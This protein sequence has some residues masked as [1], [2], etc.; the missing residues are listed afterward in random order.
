MKEDSINKEHLATSNKIEKALQHMNTI[1]SIKLH[2]NKKL[3]LLRSYHPRDFKVCP[4]IHRKL[5]V[6]RSQLTY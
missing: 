5:V 3:K 1:K 2:W 6:L 4:F